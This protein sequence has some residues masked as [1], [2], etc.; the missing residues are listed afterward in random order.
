LE[1]TKNGMIDSEL[2]IIN[3]LFNYGYRVHDVYWLFWW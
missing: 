1:E 3:I 2:M